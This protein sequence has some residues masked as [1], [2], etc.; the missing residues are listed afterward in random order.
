MT[1]TTSRQFTALE[2]LNRAS[3]YGMVVSL[4]GDNL[5]IDIPSTLA[6]DEKER[7]IEVMRTCK[8]EIVTY[9][10]SL[11]GPAICCSCLDMDPPIETNADWEYDGIM[12]CAEHFPTS[13]EVASPGSSPNLLDNEIVQAVS[14]QFNA[15]IVEVIPTSEWTQRKAELLKATR[16]RTVKPIKRAPVFQRLV[17]QWVEQGEDFTGLD[18][19]ARDWTERHAHLERLGYYDEVKASDERIL[20]RYWEKEGNA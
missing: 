17:D 7:A 14:R 8:P 6:Q 12:Y 18:W 3:E 5:A 13:G 16:A 10:C 15:Q 1:I 4:V 2:M 9:L 20:S 11:A 19:Q